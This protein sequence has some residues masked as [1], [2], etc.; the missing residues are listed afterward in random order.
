M[1]T[2]I[3]RFKTK[4]EEQVRNENSLYSHAYISPYR[5]MHFAT[6]QPEYA[7]VLNYYLQSNGNDNKIET[8]RNS[9]EPAIRAESQHISREQKE[10]NRNAREI[11]V[12]F[13]VS[14]DTITAKALE[15]EAQ[16]RNLPL[17]QVQAQRNELLTFKSFLK[18][19]CTV[20]NEVNPAI[21][22][23][24]Q[25]SGFNFNLLMNEQTTNGNT[26]DENKSMIEQLCINLNE[27]A[28]A[29][30]ITKVIGRDKEIKKVAIILGKKNKNNP[31]LVGPAGVGKTAIP[32]G[33]ALE[34]VEGNVPDTLK[35]AVIYSLEVSSML[36]GTSFRGQFE[37][38]MQALMKEFQAIEEKGEIMPVLF[39]DEIHQISGGGGGGGLGFADIIKPALAKG[40]LRTIGATTDAE[41][42][43]F[44]NQEKALRRRFSQILVVEPTREETIEILRGAKKYYETKHKLEITD[45]A[46]VSA[47]DLSIDFIT[48]SKMPDKSLDLLDYTG[49]MFRIEGSVSIGKAEIEKGLSDIKRIPLDK[50]QQKEVEKA[51]VK[52][53]GPE[54]KK[55]LF[56]Q[57]H[58][59]DLI[60]ER[61]ETNIAG[62]SEDNKPQGC[63]L[64]V[65]PTG[66]G[67][68]ELAK[69]IAKHTGAHFARIN[70]SEY[71]EKHSVS[72]LLGAPAG[73]IGYDN[74]A[75]LT[76]ILEANPHCVLLLDEME[77]AHPDI[78]DIFLQVMDEGRITDRQG[79]DLNFRN[80]TVLMTSNLGARELQKSTMGF[81]QSE[82]T[83]QSKSKSIMT[84]YLKPEFINRLD[85]VVQF[86]A[87]DK[88]LM[89]RVVDK[90]IGKMIENTL[91]KKG[92]NLTLTDSAKQYLV[93]VGYDANMGARPIERSIKT[94]IQDVLAKSILYGEIKKG[95]KNVSVDLVDGSLKFTYSA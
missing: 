23:I 52:P 61:L 46:I 92:I 64:C 42:N 85:A 56:G 11:T 17:D 7:Q 83:Q 50:I 37:E 78:H 19:T 40:K 48:D 28:K 91:S 82:A 24:M 31:A 79:N 57:D 16:A 66:V 25:Q 18:G 62:F 33:L 70:M 41:W 5:L 22:Q 73:Y 72:G 4:L 6:T 29:G 43:K 76:Q 53:I 77:K 54:I 94:H 69:L 36:A 32:E 80:V 86:N 71:M 20:M 68:T 3:T 63:F 10:K 13:N 30:R 75:K 49:S 58:A 81:I 47:V 51:E 2:L 93:D 84:N 12:Q 87:L 26:A 8:L 14:I 45:E 55:E 89:I 60:V 90:T 67:K 1:H 34:I 9:L 74:G 95:S 59:V 35:N 38:K 15:Y 65:G 88:S 44:I 39:I 27:E 21:L